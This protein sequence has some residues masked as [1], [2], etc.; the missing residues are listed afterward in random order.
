M[1]WVYSSLIVVQQALRMLNKV[2]QRS[3]VRLVYP[4]YSEIK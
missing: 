2:E 3:F 1:C 4:A